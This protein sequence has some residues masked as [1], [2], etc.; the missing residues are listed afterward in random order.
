MTIT[1]KYN[2]KKP[3][4]QAQREGWEIKK[5]KGRFIR[6]QMQVKFTE[7]FT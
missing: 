4:Q 2:L 3:A 6:L 5:K 7:G 1:I